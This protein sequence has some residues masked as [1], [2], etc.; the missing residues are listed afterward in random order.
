MPGFPGLNGIPGLPG[1][2]GVRGLPGVDG[3]NG[4]DG[5]QGLQYWYTSCIVIIFTCFYTLLLNIAGKSF[6]CSNNKL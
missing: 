5:P 4:T 3:C 1:D 2:V 6:P